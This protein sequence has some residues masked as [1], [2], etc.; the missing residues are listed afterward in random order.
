M[1]HFLKIRKRQSSFYQR[2]WH[3][4]SE[5]KVFDTHEHLK[6]ERMLK[7]TESGKPLDRI[8]VKEVFN[9]AYF[10]ALKSD[11]SDFTG[12]FEWQGATGD[13]LFERLSL[14]A[15]HDDE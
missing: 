4:V 12:L 2:M 8:Y 15:F 9:S 13:S 11:P 3:E 14:V 6:P 7:L 1:G 10:H 5:M